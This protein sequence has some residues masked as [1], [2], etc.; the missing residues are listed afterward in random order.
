MRRHLL[1]PAA[2]GSLSVAIMLFVVASTFG[3]GC[4]TSSSP[5]SATDSGGLADLDGSSPAS[6]GAQ[7]GTDGSSPLEA[8]GGD[9]SDGGGTVCT[10]HLPTGFTQV[11][12]SVKVANTLTGE[13]TE[14]GQSMVLDEN[15]DPMIAYSSFDSA[16]AWS[17]NFT[18]WDAC[19]GA[20]TTPTQVDAIHPYTGGVDV[21]IAYDP[22][23]KEIGIAYEK[24]E[25]S[26]NW[27][28]SF[29]EVWLATMTSAATTFTTQPLASGETD[30][31]ASG[32][33]SIAMGGGHLYVGFWQGPYDGP[34]DFPYVV[35][36]L[37]STATPTQPPALPGDG[38]AGDSGATFPDAGPSPPH[39]FNYEAVPFNGTPADDNHV[40]A[41]YVDPDYGSGEVSVAIDSNGVPA[42]AAF[43]AQNASDNQQL[44]FWRAGTSNAISVYSFD[45][46][47]TPDVTLAFEGTKPR[48]AGHVDQPVASG[49]DSLAFFAS[50][51]GVTWTAPSFLPDNA[52]SQYTAFDSTMALDGTGHASVASDINS[53][54]GAGCGNNP[55]VATS[56]DDDAG[57]WTACGA[58][59]TKV[60]AFDAYSA[61]AAYGTSRVNGTLALSFISAD[62][63]G[64]TAGTDKAGIIFWLHP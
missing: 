18:R 15:D 28:D 63:G 35:W 56:S 44:L 22:S 25:T 45:L 9:A 48:L 38:G 1:H 31:G 34:V 17:V 49:F 5:S 4:I 13:S 32:S 27:T 30:F 23:T 57:A 6:D 14:R 60:H 39:E 62:E 26:N 8:G 47:G 51:D 59:T 24:G 29:G 43:E 16:S 55:Y 41:G 33:P 7:P 53:G 11:I 46:D 58:D 19:A 61:S 64:G 50:N 12:A 37:S 40:L 3:E 52:D 42:I 10:K 54:N 20:F 2:V 21:S 36:L